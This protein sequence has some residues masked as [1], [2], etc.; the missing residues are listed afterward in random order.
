MRCKMYKIA[1]LCIVIL[2]LSADAVASE[3]LAGNPDTLV[4]SINIV[5]YI[6]DHKIEPNDTVKVRIGDSTIWACPD[7]DRKDNWI[8]TLT[9]PRPLHSCWPYRPGYIAYRK[10]KVEIEDTVKWIGKLEF[11][12]HRLW[13][14]KVESDPMP[15][16]ISMR[17]EGEICDSDFSQKLRMFSTP[18]KADSLRWDAKLHMQI[19]VTEKYTYPYI[20]QASKLEEKG[21]ISLKSNKFNK[22]IA[23]ESRKERNA[24]RVTDPLKMLDKIRSDEVTKIKTVTFYWID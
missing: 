13:E 23:E 3:E 2:S 12:F 10:G 1:I 20:L 4:T 22:H 11:R 5:F 18:I 15:I 19:H 9:D 24:I 8:V 17:I 7:P 21:D 6:E 14:A 16:N